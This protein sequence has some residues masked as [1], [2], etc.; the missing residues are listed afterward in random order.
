MAQRSMLNYTELKALDELI[1]AKY[2][3]VGLSDSMF[4][5][6]VNQFYADKFRELITEGNVYGMRK[7]LGIAPTNEKYTPKGECVTHLTSRVAELEDQVKHLVQQ[8][9]SLM[10]HHDNKV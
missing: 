9:T 3:E 7:T 8:V 2:K 1:T 10:Y 4:A 6:Y 5:K